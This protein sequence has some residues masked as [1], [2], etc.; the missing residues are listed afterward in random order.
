MPNTALLFQV[1][2]ALGSGLAAIRLSWNGLYRRYPVL[3]SYLAFGVVSGAVPLVL[4]SSSQVYFAVYVG[5]QP[6]IWMFYVLMVREVYGLALASH[7]GLRTLG[8]WAMYAATT[9]SVGVSLLSILPKITPKTP[10]ISRSIG[11]VF[12]VD[13]GVNFALVL[14]ILLILFFLSRYPVPLSQNVVRHSS[15]LFLYFLSNTAAILLRSIYGPGAI[16]VEI[17]TV[18]TGASTVVS[19]AWLFLITPA[20]EEIRKVAGIAPEHEQRILEQLDSL[21]AALLKISRN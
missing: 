20:G 17:S 9:V 8:R 1:V 3:C 2:A 13:R 18:L 10:Q 4:K 21:N 5:I 15:I 19:L 11:Y 6:L 12:A 16:S 7:L 14:F